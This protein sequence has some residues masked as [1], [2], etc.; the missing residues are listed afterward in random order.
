MRNQ[1]GLSWGYDMPINL[2]R[3]PGGWL[4]FFCHSD[5]M[6]EIVKIFKLQDTVDYHSMLKQLNKWNYGTCELCPMVK[7]LLDWG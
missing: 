5:G 3:C 2:I 1:P 4:A 7:A 6:R